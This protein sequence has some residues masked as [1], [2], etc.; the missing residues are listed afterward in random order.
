MPPVMATHPS[1]ETILAQFLP[2][3][4]ARGLTLVLDHRMKLWHAG[5]LLPVSMGLRSDPRWREVFRDPV[6]SVYL[7]KETAE[8]LRLPEVPPG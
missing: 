4:D 1:W 8:A 5:V 7:R 2:S 6:A 3:R